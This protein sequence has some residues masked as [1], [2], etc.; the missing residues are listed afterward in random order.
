MI[1]DDF[2]NKIEYLQKIPKR[3]LLKEFSLMSDDI[4]NKIKNIEIC[5]NG[6]SLKII[7]DTKPYN[8]LLK[9]PKYYPF[10]AIECDVIYQPHYTNKL[11]GKVLSNKIH[12]DL[13]LYNNI[14][15]G[16]WKYLDNGKIIDGKKFIYFKNKENL[17]YGENKM[18]QFDYIYTNW[19]PSLQIEESL[20]NYISCF[21]PHITL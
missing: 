18:H 21:E 14:N 16:I 20:N 9:L 17:D 13:S 7:F 4:R 12:P 8:I 3:R 5:E 2:L 10:K 19:A 11:I 6:M 15:Y 1:L